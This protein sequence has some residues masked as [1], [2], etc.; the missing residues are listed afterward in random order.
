MNDTSLSFKI[1]RALGSDGFM[2]ILQAKR[3]RGRYTGLESSIIP[4]LDGKNPGLEGWNSLPADNLWSQLKRWQ[5]ANLGLRGDIIQVLDCDDLYAVEAV[6]RK[7]GSLGHHETPYEDTNKGRHYFIRLFQPPASQNMAVNGQFI[8]SGKQAVI[9]PSVINGKQRELIN[10]QPENLILK[11]PFLQVSDLEGILKPSRVVQEYTDLKPATNPIANYKGLFPVIIDQRASPNDW[12]LAGLVDCAKLPKGSSLNL[13]GRFFQSRSHLEA[14]AVAY[15]MLKGFGFDEIKEVFEGINPG[16][17]VDCKAKGYDWLTDAWQRCLVLG[18]R[19]DLENL[20]HR[21][22]EIKN[23][24]KVFKALV[25][26]A[27]QFCKVKA[28]G[29][30]CAV[31]ADHLE[32][33]AMTVKRGL[34][35]LEKSGLIA[36]N[37]GY[38]DRRPDH[39]QKYA[40]NGYKRTTNEFDL[41]CDIRSSLDF[42]DVLSKLT[43]TDV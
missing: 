2:Q 43:Q 9:A 24:D 14:F 7:M 28:F 4:V 6:A 23:S 1:K 17:Y 8:S 21:L 31:L 15:L 12:I 25:K 18:C 3:E 11:T 40:Q 16:H 38:S 36:I 5:E 30:S 39:K 34:D 20:Y 22:P 37:R 32:I 33:P 19:P 42:D 13:K 10:A 29:V 26:V 41:I 35:H 27:W